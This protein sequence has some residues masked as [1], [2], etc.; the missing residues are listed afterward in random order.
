MDRLVGHWSRDMVFSDLTS[1]LW[2]LHLW[3]GPM[4]FH[5]QFEFSNFRTIAF[6]SPARP[7]LYRFLFATPGLYR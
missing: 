7:H 2:I 4:V 1:G 3:P 5:S 6:F